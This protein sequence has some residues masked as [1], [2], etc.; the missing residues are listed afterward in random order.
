MRYAEFCGDGVKTSKSSTVKV[1]KHVPSGVTYQMFSVHPRFYEPPV[2]LLG[3]DCAEQ[4]L[5]QIQ[6]DVARI[7]AWLEH[8]EPQPVL[9]AEE[10]RAFAEATVCHICS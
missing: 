10:Q 6:A 5:D 9:T 1:S 3:S 4:F 7:R 2:T 8:P